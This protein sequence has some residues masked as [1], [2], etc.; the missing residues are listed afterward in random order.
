MTGVQFGMSMG[1][2]M[3]IVE[4]DKWYYVVDCGKCDRG[5]VLSEAR[6]SEE[7]AR[8]GMA[9]FFWKCPY[10]G[11]RQIVHQ[12]KVERCQGIYL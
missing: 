2:W 9:T 7:V 1:R 12:E 11:N 3:N 4:R 6:S 5:M 8:P 10:C